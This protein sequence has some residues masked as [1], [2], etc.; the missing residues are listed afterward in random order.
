MHRALRT[1]LS[2]VSFF[3]NSPDLGVLNPQLLHFIM[4]ERH[5]SSRSTA[6]IHIESEAGQLC[7][8]NVL[9]HSSR[10]LKFT[11]LYK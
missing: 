7:G 6:S 4:S 8:T 3:L 11:I 10:H 9:N 5:K 2:W 1:S